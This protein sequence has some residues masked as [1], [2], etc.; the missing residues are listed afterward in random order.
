MICRFWNDKGRKIY[1]EF[2]GSY[3]GNLRGVVIYFIDGSILF[4]FV[5]KDL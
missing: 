4:D 3:L 2:R 1:E 5:E